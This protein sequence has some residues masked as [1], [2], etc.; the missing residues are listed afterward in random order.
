MLICVQI[1]S[2]YQSASVSIF[3][4]LRS[5]D[6]FFLISS[7]FIR[8]RANL[9]FSLFLGNDLGRLLFASFAT[10]REAN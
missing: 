7:I 4:K 1:L 8:S 5:T 6:A 3:L 2:P 10:V 9:E